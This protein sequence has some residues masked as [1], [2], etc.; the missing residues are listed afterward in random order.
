MNITV[1]SNPVSSDK[2]LSFEAE[3][4]GDICLHLGITKDDS[5]FTFHYFNTENVDDTAIAP[6]S[7]AVQKMSSSDAI[8][9]V[10]TWNKKTRSIDVDIIKLIAQA[11][12]CTAYY[13]DAMFGDRITRIDNDADDTFDTFFTEGDLTRI[14]LMI[15]KGLRFSV[16]Y[17]VLELLTTKLQNIEKCKSL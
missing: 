14:F 12:H 16:I 6:L 10:R 1:Y 3:I 8:V 15:L 7:N 4:T 11:Y 17:Q 2:K 9:F 5:R 13:Y